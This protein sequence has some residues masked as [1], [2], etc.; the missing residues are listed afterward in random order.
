MV[1]TP[2]IYLDMTAED[3]L[4]EQYRIIGL[5]S[6]DDIPELLE[7]VGLADTGRKKAKNFSLE[8]GQRLGIAIALAGNP[9]FLVLDEPING[10][11]SSGHYRSPGT[12]SETEPGKTASL[13]LYPATSST[14][15]EGWHPLRIY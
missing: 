15:W 3:N 7:L 14:N 5:P 12:D 11:G 13:F 2:S 10:P 1:E 9:D 4:K 6:F 8:C